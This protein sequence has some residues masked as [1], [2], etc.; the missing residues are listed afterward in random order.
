MTEYNCGQY[1]KLHMDRKS[2]CY[3]N[4]CFV[5]FVH[6]SICLFSLFN[7]DI[8][9]IFRV[10][11]SCTCAF[12]SKCGLIPVRFL[13]FGLYYRMRFF[14]SALFSH[15][16]IYICVFFRFAFFLCAFFQCA[17]FRSPIFIYSISKI[18]EIQSPANKRSRGNIT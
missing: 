3:S 4:H 7:N 13:P 5:A 2:H 10:L 15:A 12:S 6:Y 18:N 9:I 17:L 16:L 14:P 8:N 1:H 11:F